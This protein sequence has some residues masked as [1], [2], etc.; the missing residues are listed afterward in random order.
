MT[1]VLV[2]GG[3]GN[4]GMYAVAELVRRGCQVVIYD[5]Q[6]DRALPF[7]LFENVALVEGDI[8]DRAKLSGLIRKERITHILHLAAYLGPESVFQPILAL[9]INCKGTANI[10]DL[11]IKHSLQ[12]VCWTS[13]IGAIGTMPDYDGR[14]VDEAY[15]VAPTTTYGASKYYCE[16]LTQ[17]YRDKGL[18]V[19][20]VRPAFAFGLG[21]LAGSWGATY[22]RVI[23]NAAVGKPSVFPTWA[24]TGLQIIYNRDQAKLCVDATLASKTK[25][26]LFNTPTEQPFTELEFVNLIREVVPDAAIEMDPTPA[27]GSAFPPNVTGAA[28]IDEL[29]FR[30]DYSVKDGIAEMVDYYRRHPDQGL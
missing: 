22:N 24:R 15:R 18:S 4:I 2:T 27:F 5:R 26:W 16:L 11:A 10:F 7:D 13:S 28:A 6:I 14:L 1:N 17:I 8:L 9:D 29:G 20:C 3:T 12:N 19:N 25:H 23:Y 30:H 21:K